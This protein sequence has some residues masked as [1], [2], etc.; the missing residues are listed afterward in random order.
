VADPSTRPTRRLVFEGA[1]SDVLLQNLPAGPQ[2][3]AGIDFGVQYV[4]NNT[5]SSKSEAPMPPEPSHLS[6]ELADIK[7][8]QIQMSKDVKEQLSKA[9]EDRK[10]EKP[11]RWITLLS[12]LFATVVL[13]TFTV[14]NTTRI[15]KQKQLFDQQT[16][17]QNQA[18]N[19][20]SENDFV[21]GPAEDSLSRD[22]NY[23]AMV[24][25]T[26]VDHGDLNRLESFSNDAKI[27]AS[28]RKQ[29]QAAAATVLESSKADEK[30]LGG[31]WTQTDGTIQRH[32]TLNITTPTNL[33]GAST[34]GLYDFRVHK[35]DG[36]KWFG[37]GIAKNANPQ[38]AIVTMVSCT[39]LL[40]NWE[41]GELRR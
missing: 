31:D 4:K 36:T 13:G 37:Q 39:K 32:W 3:Q 40:L 14:W 9:L 10:D 38:Q 1:G 19:L 28:L 35:F 27:D 26:A 12:T 8:L 15:E 18:L 21:R 5:F 17:S 7:A 41:N 33:Q 24:I 34:D 22:P 29:Y 2:I 11:I 6:R 20:A 23:I 30:C 16:Q 25:R